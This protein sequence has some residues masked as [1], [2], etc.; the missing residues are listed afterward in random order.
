MEIFRVFGSIFIKDEASE[1]LDDVEKKG[2]KTDKGMGTSFKSIG[3]A[4]G[5]MALSVA[6]AG[7]AIAGALGVKGVMAADDLKKS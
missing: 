5:A 2:K 3:K 7:V 1:T 6:A 4:A